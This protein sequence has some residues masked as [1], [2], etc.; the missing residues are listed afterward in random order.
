MFILPRWY[1]IGIWFGI[2][3]LLKIGPTAIICANDFIAIELIAAAEEAGLKVPEELSITGFDDMEGA[4]LSN[5]PLTTVRVSTVEMGRLAVRRLIEKVSRTDHE[6][7][8]T[9]VPGEIIERGSC[10]PPTL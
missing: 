7:I 9:L 1:L 4:G 3:W 10:A 6:E 2:S 5:P 8:V